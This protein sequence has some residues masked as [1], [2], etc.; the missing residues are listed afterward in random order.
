MI[1]ATRGPST[2]HLAVFPAQI[3]ILLRQGARHILSQSSGAAI[4]PMKR[5]L[6]LLTV[7]F[8]MTGLGC[9]QSPT[10]LDRMVARTSGPQATGAPQTAAPSA[11]EP[12]ALSA[13]HAGMV[14]I[15]SGSFLMGTDEGFAFEGPVHEVSLKA[16]WM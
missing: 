16:F 4:Y 1:R 6:W 5:T 9:H 7:C 8:Q 12:S 14:L 2:S 13:S 15:A 11:S 3:E 10:S